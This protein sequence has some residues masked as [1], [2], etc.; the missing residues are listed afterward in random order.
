MRREAA[1][2]AILKVLQFMTEKCLVVRDEAAR[3]HVDQTALHKRLAV[4]EW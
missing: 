1:Y 2:T 3:T 4:L